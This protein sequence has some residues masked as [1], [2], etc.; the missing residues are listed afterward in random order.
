MKEQPAATASRLIFRRV[1]DRNEWRSEDGRWLIEKSWE[2][3][4]RGGRH[5][6]WHLYRVGD[7]LQH[8]VTGGRLRDL[9]GYV[10][11]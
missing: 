2:D 8:V 6:R 5:V 11:A 3:G 10:D 4:P 7:R 1:E 9:W